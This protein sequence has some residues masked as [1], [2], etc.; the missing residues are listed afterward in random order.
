MGFLDLTLFL[1][2]LF[3]FSILGITSYNS[4]VNIANVLLFRHPYYADE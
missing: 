2:I 3:A 4:A 1:L